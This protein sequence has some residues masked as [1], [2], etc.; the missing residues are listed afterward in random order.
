[1]FIKF[2]VS[3]IY[4]LV[5]CLNIT[6]PT[7]T[8]LMNILSSLSTNLFNQSL[9][10]KPHVIKKRNKWIYSVLYLAKTVFKTGV[11]FSNSTIQ[12]R[13]FMRFIP[14]NLLQRPG[15]GSVGHK[16]ID[17]SIRGP[18]YQRVSF[19]NLCGGG[20]LTDALA[21]GDV[22][23]LFLPTMIKE[24][25]FDWLIVVLRAWSC[26]VFILAGLGL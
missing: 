2:K 18:T 17:R 16:P 13:P 19:N 14:V 11:L 6:L 12:V 24:I 23:C 25:Y 15:L 5:I 4:L 9:G 3:F 21:S 20:R 8:N 7:T 10:T 1:M 26:S 22:I